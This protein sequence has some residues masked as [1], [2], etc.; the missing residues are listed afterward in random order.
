MRN[1]SRSF[2]ALALVAGLAL[3]GCGGDGD[4]SSTGPSK[5]ELRK[6]E[7]ESLAAYACMPASQKRQ[8]RSLEARHDARVRLLAGRAS[9]ATGATGPA[10]TTGDA[11]K[12]T[13]ESDR[14]RG[15]LL[16]R[17]RAIYTQYLPGGK[18]Y[19]GGCFLREREKAR[20]RLEQLGS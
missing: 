19:D 16:A 3:A 13:V 12:R 20:K 17:A 4:D 18:N 8:L 14:V 10:G 9:G 5:E 2:L 7:L 1:R 11:F 6:I 15:R